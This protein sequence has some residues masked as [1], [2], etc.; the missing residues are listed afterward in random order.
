MPNTSAYSALKRPR[1]F[2]FVGLAAQRTA[3]H[4]L[5]EKLRTECP[6]AQ[7]VGDRVRVPAL[8][9]HGDGDHAADAA[10]QTARLADG[11]H[12]FAQQILLGEFLGLGTVAGAFDDLA[13]EALD[14]AGGGRPEAL[15][16][17]F[18]GFELAAVDEQRPGPRQG[19][20]RRIVVAEQF[21]TSVVEGPAP[22]VGL[23]L[24]PRDVVVDKLGGRDVVADDDEARRLVDA[25]LL[26][27]A[28]RLLVVAVEGFQG[29]L[30]F[31]R[32]VHRIE[33]RAAPPL[34]HLPADVLPE[35][36]EHRHLGA[37]DVV[38]HRHARQL[39]DAALDGVHQGEVADR[40]REQRALG[41]ARAA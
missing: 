34:R 21:Q 25:R 27:E 6:E 8:G 35:I 15:V 1:S 36:A 41:V 38:H 30:Q 5:A 37:G 22:I 20:A 31:A 11:V 39:D 28:E 13:P 10:A 3:D 12:R 29:R 4:L 2:Q 19:N 9:E 33:R 40:P 26:P 17:R 7:H 14:L 16:E 24:E 32:Q 18:A 23:P